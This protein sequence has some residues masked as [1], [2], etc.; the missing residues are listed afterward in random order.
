VIVSG[1]LADDVPGGKQ[2]WKNLFDS[3]R[4]RNVS[5]KEEVLTVKADST[6]SM[7]AAIEPYIIVSNQNIVR[8]TV[9]IDE[10]YSNG[11]GW[12]VIHAN[13]YRNPSQGTVIGYTNV[14]DGLNKDVVVTLN[15]AKVTRKLYAVLHQDGHTIGTFEYPGPDMPFTSKGLTVATFFN[16]WP[17]REILFDPTPYYLIQ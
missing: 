11:P 3:L 16:N 6:T 2:I 4:V 15:M 7:N 17:T 9:T 5:T 14:S 13:D 12:L 10:A 1:S 8:G